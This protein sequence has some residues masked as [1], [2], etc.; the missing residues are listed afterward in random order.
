[1]HTRLAGNESGYLRKEKLATYRKTK[2]ANAVRVVAKVSD[3]HKL[4]NPHTGASIQAVW[5]SEMY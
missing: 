1:M 2:T 4:S 3:V 5:G